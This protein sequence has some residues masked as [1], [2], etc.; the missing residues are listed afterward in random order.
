MISQML[1]TAPLAGFVVEGFTPYGRT[2]SNARARLMLRAVHSGLPVVR[3]GRCNTEGFVPLDNPAFIGGSNLTATKARLLLMAC[4]M[5]LGALP[6]AA[7][8]DQP[9]AEETAACHKK[10]A[11]YQTVFDTH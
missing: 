9:T 4:L 11:E 6:P 2:A 1:K 10:V 3:V 5:K 8:P 7:N